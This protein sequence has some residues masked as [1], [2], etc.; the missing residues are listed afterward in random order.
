MAIYHCD[1]KP[2]Q[3]SKGQTT[4]A[5][6]AY[7][8]GAKIEDKRTGKTH[9]YTAKKGVEHKEI[10]TPQGVNIPSREDLWNMAELAE[11]RKDACTGREYEFTFMS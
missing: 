1:V 8:A 5:K 2:V 4:T 6:M 9:D 7:R 11:R 3:R 10:I